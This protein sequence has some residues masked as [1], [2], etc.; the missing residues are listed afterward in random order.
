LGDLFHVPVSL[1]THVLECERAKGELIVDLRSYEATART[2]EGRVD[3]TDTE[4]ASLKTGIAS[5]DAEI[6]LRLPLT[7]LY[8]KS[9][10]A[11][12]FVTSSRNIR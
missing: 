6:E 7:R 2:H 8:R 10:G 3:V 9:K 4:I 5:L 11:V 1:A 12:Q